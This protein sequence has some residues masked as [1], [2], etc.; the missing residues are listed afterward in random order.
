MKNLLLL[1]LAAAL[2]LWSGAHSA[3][4][5]DQPAADTPLAPAV[6]PGNGLAQHDFFYAGEGSH[7][8]MYLVRKGKVVWSY[9]DPD[10]KG[11]ISDA[12][13]MSNGNVLFAHQ[14]GVSEITPDKKVVWNYTAPAGTEIH[15][16]QPI[17][18]GHV[19]FIQNGNPARLKVVNTVSGETE[20][21]FVLPTGNPTSTHGQFRH[22]RLTDAGTI[23][24]AHMDMGKICEYDITGKEV[25]SLKVPS[26]WTAVPLKNGNILYTNE[27]RFVREVNRQGETVWEFTP[28]SV[29]EIKIAGMQTAA[30]LANGNT[31]INSWR[32]KGNGTAVQA[33]EVSPDKKLVWGL[34]S[35]TDPDL[36]PS[37]IIQ[38]LDEPGVPENVH[39]GDIK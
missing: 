33:F 30:R 19:V 23:L 8:N 21:D 2:A 12:T 6:L 26:V 29:P 37:T 20:K 14:F 27:R 4:A 7:Q 35:W 36:G 15:T 31:L 3:A 9:N 5:Q 10:A 22:A 25:W 38:V 39:F 34:R 28:A 1:P 32:T 24:V 11:E 16:A 17:G 18:T 13:L